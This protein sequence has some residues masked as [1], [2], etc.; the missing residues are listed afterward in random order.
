M[1]E[2]QVLVRRLHPGRDADIELP[3]AAS[4]GAAGFDLRAAV[5]ISI[6]PGSRVLVQT[7]LSVAL[8]HGYELQLRPR[9]GLAFRHGIT[10]LN[11]P[12]TVDSDYR[13]EL[14]VIL[15]NFGSEAFTI[16]RGDRIAQGVV[17]ALPTVRWI[18]VD[19][20]PDTERGG[21]GF[22]STGHS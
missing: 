17:S 15:V 11:S 14:K 10:V 13:G 20:L 2:V 7:G 18:E 9:S 19:E 5:G 8:P 22:G 1:P 3:S 6:K 12:G 4:S 21:G 16:E